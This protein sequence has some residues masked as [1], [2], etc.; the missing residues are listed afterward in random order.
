MAK[1]I[2]SA[3][4]LTDKVVA[5]Q[6]GAIGQEAREN[7]MGKNDEHIKKIKGG[8]TYIELLMAPLKRLSAM[9][10]QKDFYSGKS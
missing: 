8:L 4:D 6:S 7:S 3:R 2:Q 9:T 5:V 10:L 1:N